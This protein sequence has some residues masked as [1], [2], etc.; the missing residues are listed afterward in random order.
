V[1]QSQA[2]AE[3]AHAN[4]EV[5]RAARDLAALDMSYTKIY[6]PHDGVISKRTVNEGQSVAVGQAIAQVV[7]P[8]VWVTANFKET[9]LGR[10]RVGQ[11]VRVE[12]DSFSHAEITGDVES[13]SGATG[14]KFSLLPPDNATGNYTKIVQ[15][16]PVRIRLHDV[17]AGLVLRPGMS[18][19]VTVDTR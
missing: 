10:M 12:V 15:R 11:P 2:K 5:A 9:Q 1:R 18:A 14:A 4:A 13:I 3:E 6:A 7:T 19:D 16:V 17:P 8:H